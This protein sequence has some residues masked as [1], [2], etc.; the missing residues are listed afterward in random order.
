MTKISIIIP[1]L[2]S[3]KTIKKTIT[4][5]IN[6]SFKDYEI[7]IIDSYSMDNTIKII[8][9][10]NSKIIRVFYLPK[11]KNLSYARYFGIL[12]SKGNYISFLDS[13]DYWH[14]DKLKLQYSFM[15]KKNISF[16]S[17]N[18]FLFKNLKKKKFNYKKNI[19]FND[20]LFT[21]PIAN[22]SVM[23][24]KRIILNIAKR[25]QNISYAEDY[26]W[27]LKAS[28]KTKI[29]NMQKNLTYIRVS[30]NS[31]TSIGIVKNLKS[32]IYIYT[33]IY[34]F[35]FIKIALIFLRLFFNNFEKKFF[36]YS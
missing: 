29:L 2:N 8:K 22:S 14:R 20:L 15:K 5:V 3:S 36:Y 18:F 19:F 35:S 13:D 21:R 27:W 11:S 16:T 31:R 28:E 26:L 23:V 9:K 7:I 34:K 32:L 17:T 6:Q 4:S 10:F 12:K 24:K 30:D 25:Y 33:K 1:T